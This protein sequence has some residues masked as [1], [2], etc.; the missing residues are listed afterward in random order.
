MRKALSGCVLFTLLTAGLVQADNI[1]FNNQGEGDNW[2]TPENW[3]GG[4]VPGALD[5]AFFNYAGQDATLTGVVPDIGRLVI[6][7]NEPGGVTVDGGTLVTLPG[8]WSAVGYNVEDAFLI[9]KNGGSVTYGQRVF[10][11]V[12]DIGGTVDIYDGFIR[13]LNSYTHNNEFDN[14]FTNNPP[15]TSR[16][17]IHPGGLLDVNLLRLKG[18]VMDVAGGTV[19]D[20]SG[21]VLN[22]VEEWVGDGRLVAFGGDGLIMA[23]FG[24]TNPGWTTITSFPG[25]AFTSA[26][27]ANGELVLQWSA[28]ESSLY[29]VNKTPVLEPEQ[30]APIAALTDI[31]GVAGLLTVTTTVDQ[32]HFMAYRVD[33]APEPPLFFEDFDDVTAPSLPLG[34]SVGVAAGDSG[35]T[36]WQLGNPM[37]GPTA[38]PPDANSPDNCV[39]TNITGDYGVNARIWLRS[40]ATID[41]TGAASATLTFQHW[42]DI[43]DFDPFGDTGTIRIYDAA[44]MAGTPVEI[45]VVQGLGPTEWVEYSA[46]LP[47]EVLNK[48]LVLEFYFESDGFPG[49]DSSGWYIDDVSV[50]VP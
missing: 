30:W 44:N 39:G 45:D 25:T 16:T 40:P 18:G 1:R 22:N 14:V 49:D 10:L 36:Q 20:R 21:D 46:A 47:A 3:V 4:N 9:I 17:T 6:G 12:N 15:S 5:G 50:T 41:L 26:S 28:N 7:D 43:D 27:G 8:D 13:V 11:G 38:G 35:T 23:D 37:G 31:P 19:I 24:E 33:Q 29:T 34:W 2:M 32:A 48:T 42:L